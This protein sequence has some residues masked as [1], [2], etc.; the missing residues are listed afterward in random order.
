MQKANGNR[1]HNSQEF[2]CGEVASSRWDV[3]GL[4]GWRRLVMDAAANDEE[5]VP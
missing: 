4:L 5:A 2:G 3:D 1:L